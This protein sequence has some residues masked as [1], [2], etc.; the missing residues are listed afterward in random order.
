MI[1]KLKTFGTIVTTDPDSKQVISVLGAEVARQMFSKINELVEFSHK[2]EKAL[3]Y[4][5]EEMDSER[6]GL[7][8][9]DGYSRKQ[10]K[11]ILSEK[12]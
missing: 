11:R 7:V 2:V 4:L 12:S 3:V 6:A 9:M 5:A 1:E 8:D 10:V